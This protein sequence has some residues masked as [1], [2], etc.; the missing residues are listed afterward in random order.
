MAAPPSLQEAIE[1]AGSPIN[2][3]WKPNAPAWV[4]PVVDPEYSG[5]AAEQRAG[6]ETASLSDLSHHMR[7]L[8]IKGPDATKLLADYSAN[9]YEKFVVGQAKQFVPVNENG[10]IITD[11]IL[12]RR[13]EDEYI[14]TGPPASMSW[15]LYHGQKGD[16]KVDFE[17]DPDSEFRGGDPV[18][19]RYQIQGP[20]ALD[21]VSKVFGGPLPETKFFH[22]TPATLD[23]R[24][25]R[26]FRHGMAGQP[27]YEFIGDY[28]D[29]EFLREA[30]MKAGED[31]GIVRVG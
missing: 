4:P 16:Y 19:S 5:W 26:A 31:S 29:G 27:G 2:L 28:K 10:D 23:G 15:I 14:L 7:D 18:L 3:I 1:K 20:A 17:D 21:I 11:G 13:A 9:N 8:F 30:L 22:S 6:Y 25:Y 12:M 24:E